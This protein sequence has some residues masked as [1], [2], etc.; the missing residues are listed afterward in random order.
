MDERDVITSLNELDDLI[1]D[2]RRRRERATGVESNEEGGASAVS[3]PIPYVY[4][5]RIFNS[6][7]IY[8]DRPHLL[9]PTSLLAA[10]L[11]PFLT[12]QS[13]SF[14]SALQA[15]QADNAAIADAI[16]SQRVEIE[17]LLRALQSTVADLENAANILGGSEEMVGIEKEL[18]SAAAVIVS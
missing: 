7:L 10:H 15:T 1:A 3:V 6:V 18:E 14:T 17:G 5:Q 11:A 4:P 9:A 8:C 12:S 13:A 16:T 2:A